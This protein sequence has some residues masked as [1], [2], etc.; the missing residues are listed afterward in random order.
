MYWQRYQTLFPGKLLFITEFSNNSGAVPPAV[1]GH[2]YAKYFRMLRHQ[3]AIGAAFAFALFWQTDPNREGW[4]FVNE[5]GKFQR[6]EIS[7]ELGK[8]LAANPI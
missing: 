2:Q 5:D 4:V 3:K 8:A 1:K 7:D 6:S